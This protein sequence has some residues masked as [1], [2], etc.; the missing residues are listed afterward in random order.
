M[1]TKNQVAGPQQQKKVEFLPRGERKNAA[2]VPDGK[3]RRALGD[4][5]NVLEAKPHN[6]ITRPITRSFGAQLLANAQAAAV[7]NKKP[8]NVNGE[9]EVRK[10]CTKEDRGKAVVNTKPA[11]CIKEDKGKE[12]AN[13]KPTVCIKE[14]KG[15]EVVNPK[16][17]VCIKEDKGK[18]VVNPKP[19]AVIE[20]S[21]DTVEKVRERSGS[22]KSRKKKV[23]TMSQVL[24]AR[25]KAACEITKK[26]KDTI[27]DIDAS[28]AGD[29]LAV[30]DYVEDLY[31]FYKHAENAFMP[32]HYMDIQVEINEKMRAI[33]GDWLIEVHCKFELMPE[34]L[35]LTFYIIDKYLSMEKVIRREL[36][37]VGISSML[38]ASKYE[39]IWAPQVEDFITI[40][41]R[42]YNQEQILGMEKL[43]L[44]KLE[45][46]LTVPTPYVFLVRFIKAAM[47]DKQLEHMVYFF[48]ELGLLQYKMVMNCPSM[49]AASAVYAARCTLSRSP[50]WTE[51][52]RRHTGFSEPELK[53]CAK[54]L[55]SSHIAAPEGKL[56]AIY[57][58]Y[59]RSEHGAV[60]LHPPAM[61]VVEE[62]KETKA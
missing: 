35:Y 22:K 10:A 9:R 59:S 61:K 47:S 31:K 56:N 46:T 39:E 34:T 44:N 5:G 48:A 20:I 41:D 53:E 15:K 13:P 36:Q 26:P 50:L 18:V 60:A 1:A 19:T 51:T 55:V 52:L 25:S 11:V 12:A 16:P 37:L 17:A 30:V 6:K 27:P 28:D 45:W 58:K 38:I 23:K 4:I 29:Q 54:M 14:D 32:C 21:P 40:S 42:A 33:L 24:S 2:P 49:L 62:S 43:I 7:P 3:N 57:K 8:G